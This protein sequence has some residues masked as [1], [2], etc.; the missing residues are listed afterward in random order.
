MGWSQALIAFA[1]CRLMTG[2]FFFKKSTFDGRGKVDGPIC[3]ASGGSVMVDLNT[4]MTL[5]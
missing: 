2:N 4:L 5:C 3:S 1:F